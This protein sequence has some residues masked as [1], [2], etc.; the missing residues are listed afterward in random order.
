MMLR[1][2]WFLVVVSIPLSCCVMYERVNAKPQAQNVHAAQVLK[3]CIEKTKDFGD[4]TSQFSIEA[5]FV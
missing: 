1:E 3:N 4:Q 2:S 5:S